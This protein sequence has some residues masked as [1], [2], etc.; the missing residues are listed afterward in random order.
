V[1]RILI[2]QEMNFRQVISR[3]EKEPKKLFLIDSLGALLTA[4]LLHV[5][6]KT[7]FEFFGVPIET[8][9][10]LSSFAAIFCVYSASCFL[11]LNSNWVPFIKAISFAN[12]F[13]CIV[14]FG[15]VFIPSFKITLAGKIY[16]LA[17]IIVVIGLVLIE[18]QV[19]R[20]LK[21]KSG[22]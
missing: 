9:T 10:L 1:P 22:S 20:S 17:E 16:F 12:L 3:L 19:A 8:L 4:V 6:L 11:L 18:L 5:V 21:Q 7:Y 2:G 14:T 15:L 13:Y